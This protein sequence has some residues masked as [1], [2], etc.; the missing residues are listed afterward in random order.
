MRGKEAIDINSHIT[1]FQTL[2]IFIGFFLISS[3]STRYDKIAYFQREKQV[4]NI[5]VC[6]I[7]KARFANDVKANDVRLRST[8][9]PFFVAVIAKMTRY[10][11]KL[12]YMINYARFFV[13]IATI[14]SIRKLP[15]LL[16][17]VTCT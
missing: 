4:C 9:L 13:S 2:N 16:F 7:V 8:V 14:H 17:L 10:R 6:Q 15:R 3:K 11:F 1:D 12:F 5:F